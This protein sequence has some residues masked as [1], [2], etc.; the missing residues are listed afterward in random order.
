M[1]KKP[2]A[3][4]TVILIVVNVAVFLFLSALGPT[5]DAVF[6]LNRGEAYDPLVVE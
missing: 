1:R 5:E 2:E 4:C 3:I 6:M